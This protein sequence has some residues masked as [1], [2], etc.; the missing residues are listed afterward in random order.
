LSDLYFVEN[1]K[2]KENNTLQINVG[3]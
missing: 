2:I 1:S 3:I